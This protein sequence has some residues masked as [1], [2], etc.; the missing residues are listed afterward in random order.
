MENQNNQNA[1]NKLQ[2]KI[3]KLDYECLFDFLYYLNNGLKSK[4]SN[5]LNVLIDLFEK[6]K[7]NL[8]IN[9][10]EEKDIVRAF[11]NHYK[12]LCLDTLP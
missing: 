2:Q 4:E 3:K 1:E 12:R 5:D 6:I 10:I 8:N 7:K 11:N 9:I